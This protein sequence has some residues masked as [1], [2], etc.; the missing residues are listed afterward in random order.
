MTGNQINKKYAKDCGHC[1]RNMLP[2]YEYERICF[3]CGYNVIKRK[4]ELFEIQRKRMN[5]I[6]RLKYG[7]H[8]FFVFV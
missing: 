6:N 7:E 1:N 8:K 2:S 3:G 5:F 4:H